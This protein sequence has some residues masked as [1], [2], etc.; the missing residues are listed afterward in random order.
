MSIPHTG[1]GEPEKNAKKNSWSSIPHTGGGEPYPWYPRFG[2]ELSIPH[3]GGGE[4]VICMSLG[5]LAERIPHTGGG[6][7]VLHFFE[8]LLKSKY[9]PHRWG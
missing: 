4:P 6:E 5:F 2:S 8:E 9:S 1:G 3:T 7:P